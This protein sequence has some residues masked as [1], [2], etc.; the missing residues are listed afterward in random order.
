MV[1]MATGDPSV[2][3]P[4]RPLS[5]PLLH[6]RLSVFHPL[7][8]SLSRSSSSFSL[9]PVVPTPPPRPP[10]T[11]SQFISVPLR[12]SN[13]HTLCSSPAFSLSPSR[14]FETP[15]LR[16]VL[17]LLYLPSSPRF[18]SFLLS[19]Q[20]S[21]DSSKILVRPT[22]ICSRDEVPLNSHRLTI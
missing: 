1:A 17:F 11:P 7:S 16:D 22:Q 14:P 3:Y 12:S 8:L 10:R 21:T 9:F 15:H 18:S 20:P 19:L 13:T 5:L 2:H 4:T 6:P